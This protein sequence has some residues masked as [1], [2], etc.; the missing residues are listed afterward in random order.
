MTEW[1]IWV[2][3]GGLEPQMKLISEDGTIVFEWLEVSVTTHTETNAC[4]WLKS[5]ISGISNKDV[6]LFLAKIWWNI[7]LVREHGLD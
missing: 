4:D 2:N 3:T 5:K 7:S 1:I 6:D